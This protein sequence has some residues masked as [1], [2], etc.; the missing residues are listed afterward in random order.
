MKDDIFFVYQHEEHKVTVPE[1]DGEPKVELTECTVN[2]NVKVDEKTV[3][4]AT[5]HV[6]N[7]VVTTACAGIAYI[8][9]PSDTITYKGY[10][11]GKGSAV[12]SKID[13]DSDPCTS[14]PIT[15]DIS[16][17]KSG[18]HTIWCISGHVDGSVYVDEHEEHKVTVSENGDDDEEPTEPMVE[19]TECTVNENVQ[20]DEKT[21]ASAAGHVINDVVT[22]AG[23]GIAY[24]AGP[25][26]TITYKGYILD[27]GKI[28]VSSRPGDSDPCTT[29][30][31]TGDILYPEEG[32]YQ[33]WCASGHMEGDVFYP[34][35]TEQHTVIV[36]GIAKEC[37]DYHERTECIE[38]NCFW[39]ND[40]CHTEPEEKEKL[41]YE[42]MIIAGT[43]VVVTLGVAY[44][45]KGR[46]RP[47]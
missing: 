12:Y 24:I 46:T 10:T 43:I 20:V 7:D 28:L 44:I 39:Y 11:I 30:S 14:I 23:A 40:S 21:I 27:K 45:A 22:D 41:P 6:I 35:E 36:T 38:H 2:E 4:G 16:Y 1:A 17:P 5:G 9:G 31:I 32:E 37:S 19:L 26:G 18:E 8:D 47:A 15:G 34:D 29:M 42:L 13:G 25:S 33:I 3:A